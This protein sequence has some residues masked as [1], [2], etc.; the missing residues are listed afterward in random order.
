MDSIV[1][2]MSS[3]TRTKLDPA[4]MMKSEKIIDGETRYFHSSTPWLERRGNLHY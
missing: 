2:A 1:K 4:L 3:G